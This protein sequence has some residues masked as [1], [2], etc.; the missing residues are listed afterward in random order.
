MYFLHMPIYLMK[1]RQVN[2]FLL[3]FT[4]VVFEKKIYLD[5][6]GGVRNGCSSCRVF[7]HYLF[8]FGLCEQNIFFIIHCSCVNVC[9][10]LFSEIY[11]VICPKISWK[12]VLV[13]KLRRNEEKIFLISLWYCWLYPDFP[14]H[15]YHCLLS[16]F[17][18]FYQDYGSIWS[19]NDVEFYRSG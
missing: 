16:F 8:L 4:M 11:F 5:L 10:K 18:T 9:K 14:L 3:G 12:T 6:N 17:Y 15:F 13:T 19:L 1:S 2:Q 7:F